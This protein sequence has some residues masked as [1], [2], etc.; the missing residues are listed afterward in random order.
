VI[1]TKTP[2]RIGLFGGGTDIPN[3]YNIH[4]GAVVNF[5]I[6]KYIYIFI[7]K[8]NEVFEEKYRL[9][10]SITELV[11]S[12]DDIKND[13][14]RESLRFLS[15]DEPLVISTQSDLPAS[16]GLGSSSSFAVGLLNALHAFKGDQVSQHQLAEEA[17]HIEINIL[18]KPIGKQDQYAAA[19]GGLNLLYFSQNGACSIKPI[20]SID[21]SI[22]DL[23]YSSILLWTGIQR[24]ADNIL[25]D[26]VRNLIENQSDLLNM[27]YQAL[28]FSENLNNQVFNLLDFKILLK[29]AWSKKQNLSK[30]IKTDKIQ[31]LISEVQS[32]G[33]SSFKLIGAGGGG[34]LF[35]TANEPT[36]SRLKDFYKK[37]YIE[38]EYEP[39]GS[40]LINM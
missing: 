19:Y 2:H 17:C 25:S 37:N 26:Q 16:S 35:I 20:W 34:F 24:S 3:F 23:F 27:K 28:N 18:K 15:I 21:N 31:K 5:T 1:I 29:D 6:K 22:N 8:H 7:K 32:F 14:I 12:R 11:N 10:Y 39:Y 13:I 40:R 38:I 30:M 4:E 33:E 36:L 9:N